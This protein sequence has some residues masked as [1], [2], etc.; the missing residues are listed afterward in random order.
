MH[1]NCLST[2]FYRRRYWVEMRDSAKYYKQWASSIPN[3]CQHIIPIMSQHRNIKFTL[4]HVKYGPNSK[5]RLFC[6]T[7]AEKAFFSLSDS[8]FFKTDKSLDHKACLGKLKRKSCTLSDHN[9]GKQET[10]KKS[11]KGRNA[12]KHCCLEMT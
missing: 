9:R 11:H 2:Q 12:M 6:P 1:T 8:T 10:N 4:N 7:A 5:Y 3:S